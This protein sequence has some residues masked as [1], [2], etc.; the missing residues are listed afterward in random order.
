MGFADSRSQFGV[1]V[2][3][4]KGCTCLWQ[5][6]LLAMHFVDRDDMIWHDLAKSTAVRVSRGCRNRADWL[7]SS[8][9]KD[10]SDFRHSDLSSNFPCYTPQTGM[11]YMPLVQCFCDVCKKSVGGYVFLKACTKSDHDDRQKKRENELAS[12]GPTLTAEPSFRRLAA[13]ADQEEDLG[14]TR[15]LPG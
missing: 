8:T 13:S 9:S 7:A 6:S 2:E 4:S 12:L 1:Y 5:E 3:V 15:T 10:L 11:H 14:L